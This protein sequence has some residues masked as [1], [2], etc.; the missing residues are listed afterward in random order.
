ME[1]RPAKVGKVPNEDSAGRKG[2]TPRGR[3]IAPL[4]CNRCCRLQCRTSKFQLPNRAR[5]SSAR[6]DRP[7]SSQASWRAGW[8]VLQ[9]SWLP[10]GGWGLRGTFSAEI[11]VEPRDRRSAACRTIAHRSLARDRDADDAPAIAG[12]WTAAPRR[13]RLSAC[14]FFQRANFKKTSKSAIANAV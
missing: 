2:A 8:P 14:H 9:A 10:G 1:K 4:A 5:R 12:I 3:T 11:A 13:S 7:G 6:S